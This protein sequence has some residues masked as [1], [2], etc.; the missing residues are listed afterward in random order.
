[1]NSNNE[2]RKFTVPQLARIWGVSPEKIRGFIRRGELRAANLASFNSTRV[3]Y[4]IDIEDIERF[5]RAR[6]IVPDQ[7]RPLPS[8][9]LRRESRNVKK[10]F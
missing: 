3:R 2:R 5:E 9:L 8:S 4:A 7:A 6:A 1:M 10:F